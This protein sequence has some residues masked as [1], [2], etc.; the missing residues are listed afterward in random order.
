MNKYL[1]SEPGCLTKIYTFSRGYLFTFLL[2]A[3]EEKAT[4]AFSKKMQVGYVKYFLMMM[5]FLLLG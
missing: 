2:L 5:Q 3:L 1:L 4:K